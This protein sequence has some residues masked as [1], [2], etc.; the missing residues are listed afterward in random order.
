MWPELKTAV[1]TGG[2]PWPESCPNAERQASLGAFAVGA[3][4]FVLLAILQGLAYREEDLAPAVDVTGAGCRKC[5]FYGATYT[6]YTVTLNFLET[7]R[8]RRRISLGAV[9]IAW[10]V[11]L[12]G[13]KGIETD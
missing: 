3:R 13:A 11:A 7:D 5:A 6:T 9:R 12:M 1:V 4:P 8:N 2:F 10:N